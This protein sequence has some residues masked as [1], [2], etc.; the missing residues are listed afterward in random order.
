MRAVAVVAPSAFFTAVLASFEG[1]DLALLVGRILLVLVFPI[2]GYLKIAGWAATVA[3]MQRQGLPA[4]T[5]T[6][7]AVVAIELG[8]PTLVILGLGP[9]SAILC[10]A[11]YTAATAYIGHPFWNAAAD[12]WF[13]QLMSFWKNIAMVGGMVVVAA[14]G[15]GRYALR[16]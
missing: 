8:L 13:D 9:R 11:L 6:A 3:L 4:P 16:P 15:P 7:A 12:V 10:L 1:L 2:A 5:L 14:V